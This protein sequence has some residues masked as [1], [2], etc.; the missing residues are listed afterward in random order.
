MSPYRGAPVRLTHVRCGYGGTGVSPEG[1][2]AVMPDFDATAMQA[3]SAVRLAE[4]ALLDPT[5]AEL[6][7]AEAPIELRIWR[8][9]RDADH[10]EITVPFPG[11]LEAG[12]TLRLRARAALT[13]LPRASTL[14]SCRYRVTLLFGSSDGAIELQGPLDAPWATAGPVALS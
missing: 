14:S 1:Y 3:V 4:L 11:A 12:V 10:N 5:G 2:C 13:L 7:R 9:G 8:P 6:A